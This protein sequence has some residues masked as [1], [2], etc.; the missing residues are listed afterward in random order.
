LETNRSKGKNLEE[1]REKNIQKSAGKK[2]D[3]RLEWLKKTQVIK[4]LSTTT[5]KTKGSGEL[6]G[7]KILSG[8]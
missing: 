7:R 8:K 6:V 2:K 4:I 5:K 1:K 3:A